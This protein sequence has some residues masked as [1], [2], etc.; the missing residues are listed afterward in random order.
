MV[1]VIIL[2]GGTGERLGGTI[3]KQYIEVNG[4]PIIADCIDVFEDCEAVWMN[5]RAIFVIYAEKSSAVLQNPEITDNYLFI[6]DCQ[7]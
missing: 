5:G 7:R 3:P 1:Y 6:M 4:R 2:S